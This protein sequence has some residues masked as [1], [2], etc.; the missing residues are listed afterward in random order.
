MNF[1]TSGSCLVLMA[2]IQHAVKTIIAHNCHIGH[3]NCRQQFFGNFVLYKQMNKVLST[4]LYLFPYQRKKNLIGTENGRYAIGGNTSPMQLIQVILPKFVLDKKNTIQGLANS[5][6]RRTLRGVSKADSR[7]DLP[8]GS[9]FFSLH[10][11]RRKESLQYFILG[12]SLR[13][14]SINGASLF[15]LPNEAAW[16]PNITGILSI[17]LRKISNTSRCPFTIL[18]GLA[19]NRQ[20]TFTRID[21]YR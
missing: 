16:K 19:L 11:L 9:S 12:C 3:A 20:A 8:P 4:S 5:T 10:T 15:E 21:K 1:S 7:Q 6:N 14:R 13:I 18:A 17:L 2:D